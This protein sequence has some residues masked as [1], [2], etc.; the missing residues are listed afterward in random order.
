MSEQ[1]TGQSSGPP[2]RVVVRRGQCFC[3]RC[4]GRLTGFGDVTTHPTVHVRRG[5]RIVSGALIDSKKNLARDAAETVF[6]DTL[7]C[8]NYCGFE[9]YPATLR[10]QF[11]SPAEQAIREAT[12]DA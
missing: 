2:E 7:T 1:K 12:R 8:E 9:V 6:E 5:G 10:D 3:P 4:D 11:R